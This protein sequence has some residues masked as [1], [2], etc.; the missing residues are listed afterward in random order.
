MGDTLHF[1][2]F[3]FWAAPAAAFLIC[4]ARS[5]L[6]KAMGTRVLAAGTALPAALRPLAVNSRR[7]AV[8][9]L[10]WD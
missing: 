10:V 4:I 8:G 9:L 5:D 1:M 2:S 6:G 3:A 7:R